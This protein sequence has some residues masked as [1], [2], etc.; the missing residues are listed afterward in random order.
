MESILLS[1]SIAL[2]TGLIMS[3]IVKKFGL[4]AVTG[5][6]VGGVL[7][8]PYFLGKLGLEGIGFT[9]M[10]KVEQLKVISEIALGFIAFL[11]GN[12]FRISQLKNTGNK[13]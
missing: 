10:Q 12:E 1:I 8:G 3:R 7:I 11:I 2:A 5:Y 4:P 9:S 13:L 6:L